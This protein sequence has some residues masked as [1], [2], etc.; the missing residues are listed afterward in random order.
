M[1]GIHLWCL[2]GYNWG[3]NSGGVPSSGEGEAFSGAKDRGLL[4]GEKAKLVIDDV[5][6]AVNG[7]YER[8]LLEGSATREQVELQK[9]HMETVVAL[10]SKGVEIVQAGGVAIT[11]Q[12]ENVIAIEALLHDA[13]KVVPER[14]A[15]ERLLM[16]GEDSAQWADQMLQSI[17]FSKE[18]RGKIG[19]DIR[20]HMG[21]PFVNSVA[22]FK[23]LEMVQQFNAATESGDTRKAADLA[24]EIEDFPRWGSPT[25]VEAAVVFA[26]DLMSP[27]VLAGPNEQDKVG[28]CFDRYVSL[29]LGGEKNLSVQTLRDGW[30]SAKQSL[31]QNVDRLTNPPD[32]GH[33]DRKKAAKVEKMIGDSLGGV[34]LA[35][36]DSVEKYVDERGGFSAFVLA[37]SGA[38]VTRESAMGAYYGVIMDWRRD[39]KVDATKLENR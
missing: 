36:I 26:A 19:D 30:I 6:K 23:R 29:N 7:E 28:G 8:A 37:G 24:E 22:H 25:S 21:M 32:S 39:T 20:Q 34:A 38:S 3:V 12:Q 2:K 1:G 16:H 15:S 10:A 5:R 11:E 4:T 35:K 14:E 9:K 33:L 27:M 18:L 13:L 31:Q 17:G